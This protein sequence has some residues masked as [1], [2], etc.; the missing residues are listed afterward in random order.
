MVTEPRVYPK[1]TTDESSKSASVS[2]RKSGITAAKKAI[3]ALHDE[4]GRT[5]FEQVCMMPPN[6]KPHLIQNNNKTTI[7]KAQ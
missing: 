2:N 4:L 7:Y 3:N 5:G 1:W 6:W